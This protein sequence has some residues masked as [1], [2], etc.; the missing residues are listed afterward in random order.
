[1]HWAGAD[2]HILQSLIHLPG[3]KAKV[4]QSYMH[5]S[6]DYVQGLQN[7]NQGS[8]NHHTRSVDFEYSWHRTAHP[9]PKLRASSK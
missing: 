1:M 8:L 7:Y 3:D 5:W 9:S 4:L 2:G 6:K